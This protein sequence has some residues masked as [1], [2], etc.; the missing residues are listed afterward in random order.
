MN[1]N[2]DSLILGADT[3]LTFDNGFKMTTHKIIFN[4][5]YRI[6]FAFCG[7]IAYRRLNEDTFQYLESILYDAMH[8]Y[9]EMPYSAFYFWLKQN[10]YSFLYKMPTILNKYIQVMLITW[11]EEIH[12]DT[13]FVSMWL[14][15]KELSYDPM[16]HKDSYAA[17]NSSQIYNKENEK[18]DYQDQSTKQLY[19]RV[20]K[21]LHNKIN[22]ASLPSIG[23]TA[24]W[25]CIQ[26]DGSIYTNIK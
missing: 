22:D 15:K 23:G 1:K 9:H 18:A 5:Q 6:C 4:E 26:K 2:K 21:T 11:N 16:L 14:P 17:G 20:L 12:F 13:L 25:I 8:K 10:I 3:Q 7:D 24:E 19:G